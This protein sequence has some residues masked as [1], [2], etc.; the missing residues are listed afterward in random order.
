[1]QAINFVLTDIYWHRRWILQVAFL[2][3]LTGCAHISA[4]D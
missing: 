4:I 1:M 2:W 3:C